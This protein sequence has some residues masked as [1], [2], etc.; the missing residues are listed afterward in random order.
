MARRFRIGVVGGDERGGAKFPLG[1]DVRRF[2][3]SRFRGTGGVRRAVGAIAAGG[4]DAVVVLVRW[5]GHPG[6]DAIRGACRRCGVPCIVVAGGETSALRA[7]RRIV[8]D[9]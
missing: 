7:V 2:G 9:G 5:I 6:C 3:S 1:V 8:E 4:L